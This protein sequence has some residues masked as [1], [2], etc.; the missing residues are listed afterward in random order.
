MA[1][2]KITPEEVKKIASLA[3][4]NLSAPEI[5][6]F[7]PQLAAIIDYVGQLSAVE[8]KSPPIPKEEVQSVS[9][10]DEVH[11]SLTS[12]SALGQSSSTQKNYFVTKAVIDND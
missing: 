11:P 9:R 10:T 3:K 1:Q 2:G 6:K 7:T 8:E 12:K 4:L 5:N